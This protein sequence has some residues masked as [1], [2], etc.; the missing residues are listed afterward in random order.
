MLLHRCLTGIAVAAILA[1]PAANAEVLR[2]AFPPKQS[3][4]P[5]ISA[6]APREIRLVVD[7]AAILRVEGGMSVISV[8]NPA[9]A[10]ASLVNHST[11]IVTGTMAGTTN[12]IALD[13]TGRVLADVL[14]RVGSRRPGMV[15]VRRGTDVEVHN[16]FSGLCEISAK[17]AGPA[18]APAGG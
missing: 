4:D 3:A 13:D 14:V 8:G 1:V 18:A 16:C 9:I 11:V 10:N 17:V 7:F 6:A 2:V 15:T 12:L 5:V